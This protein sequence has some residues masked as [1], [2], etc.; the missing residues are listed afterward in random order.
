V[1]SG[2]TRLAGI[3]GDPVRHSLSPALHN[4]AYRELGLDW[5]YLAFEVPDGSAAGG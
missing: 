3:I 5:R 4:A 2:A 1:I